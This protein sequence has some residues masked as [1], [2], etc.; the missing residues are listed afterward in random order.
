MILFFFFFFFAFP[1][2]V[3]VSVPIIIRSRDI[4]TSLFPFFCFFFV[5]FCF[6]FGFLLLLLLLFFVVVVFSFSCKRNPS[7]ASYIFLYM[8][9][10]I[11]CDS[12][13]SEFLRKTLQCIPNEKF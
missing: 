4:Y 9:K 13:L 3:K 8:I 12:S 11:H 10:D 2:H 6:F 5:F 7:R 1:I